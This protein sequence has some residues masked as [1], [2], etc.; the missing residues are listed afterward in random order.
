MGGMAPAPATELVTNGGF[1]GTVSPWV[2]AG[3]GVSHQG[4]GP[5][6]RTGN[7]YAY[8]SSSDTAS[9]SVE[10]QITLPP[11]ATRTASLTFWLNVT[12][13]EGMNAVY[14]SLFVEIRAAAGGLLAT[15]ATYTNRDKGMTGAYVMKG[16][17]D[18]RAQAGQAVRLHFRFTTD[19]SNNTSF[20]IDDVS[21]K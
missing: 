10:Q 12:S 4:M 3:E 8:L 11:A 5:N 7:G 17:F 16:P 20:R 14:D 19:R 21:V 15:V 13:A 6:P 18:L 1:E 9:G 2:L